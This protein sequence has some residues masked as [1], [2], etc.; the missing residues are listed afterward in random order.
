[1]SWEENINN[2]K[3]IFP[4]QFQ[5]ILNFATNE[6]VKHLIN[7]DIKYVWVYNHNTDING[8]WGRHNLPIFNGKT[9]NVL[10]RKIKYDF[11]LP[12]SEFKELMPFIQMG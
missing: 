3:E 5:I 7:D 11:I 4:G 12:T 10:A 2:I 9:V 6:I 8:N 1:M